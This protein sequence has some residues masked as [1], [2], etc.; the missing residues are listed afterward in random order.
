MKV[1]QGIVDVF[2]GF[3]M[4]PALLAVGAFFAIAFT[5]AL[6]AGLLTGKAGERSTWR[7]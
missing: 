7:G 5:V 2:I 6:V 1:I 3:A 4:L